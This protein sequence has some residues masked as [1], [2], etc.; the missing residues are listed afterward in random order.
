MTTNERIEFTFGFVF[1]RITNDIDARLEVFQINRFEIVK[2]IGDRFVIF[3]S[4]I[5]TKKVKP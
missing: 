4:A 1:E 5:K 2:V 3:D